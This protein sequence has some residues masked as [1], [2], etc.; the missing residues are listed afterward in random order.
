MVAP[1]PKAVPV[2]KKPEKKCSTCGRP[3]RYIAQYKRWYCSN[4]KAYEGVEKVEPVPAAVPARPPA[5]KRCTT[6]G[7]NMKY[8]PKYDKYYCYTCRAYRPVTAPPRKVTVAVKPR[9]RAPPPPPAAVPPPPKP[10]KDTIAM[11]GFYFILLAVLLF[12]VSMVI[13]L[14]VGSGAMDPA[15]IVDNG[16]FRVTFWGELLFQLDTGSGV[17][18]HFNVLLFLALLFGIFGLLAVI[19]SFAK[20][21]PQTEEKK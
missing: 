8:I 7:S 12:I 17:V 21:V 5:V 14:A 2:A 6:C 1:K 10:K 20:R 13:S 16:A 19:F 11:V 15:Y 4:C 9:A 18:T 3:L